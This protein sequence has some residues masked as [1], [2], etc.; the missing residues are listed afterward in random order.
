MTDQSG[1]TH[2]FNLVAL[3]ALLVGLGL[4]GID[5]WVVD[6]SASPD[7]PIIGLALALL[8][9]L[10]AILWVY[11]TVSWFYSRGVTWP[12]ELRDTRIELAQL[13][14]EISK[15]REELRH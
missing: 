12:S 11:P 8:P 10:T 6:I 13:R 9:G 3:L 4:A 5:L 2:E 1:P 7:S 15:L 14:D